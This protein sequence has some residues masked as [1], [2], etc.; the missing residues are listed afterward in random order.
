VEPP[1]WTIAYRKFAEPVFHRV[2]E[3]QGTWQ[4]AHDFAG[5][6]ATSHPE[7]DQIFYLPTREAEMTEFVTREDIANVMVDDGTRIPVAEDGEL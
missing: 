2:S 7:Q 4:Q 6:F 1:L 3:W 5:E